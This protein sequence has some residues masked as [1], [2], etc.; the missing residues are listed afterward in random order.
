[1][2]TNKTFINK[3]CFN[4]F[5]VQASDKDSLNNGKLSYQIVD[6]S[7]SDGGYFHIDRD[8]GVVW[9]ARELDFEVKSVLSF[10]V[11]ASDHGAPMQHT[12]VNVVLVVDDVNDNPPVFEKVS[13]AIS[14][15]EKYQLKYL[16][17]TKI[18]LDF[19]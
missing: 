13:V 8:T 14:Y 1:M 3:D 11:R 18:C 2:I 9:T 5:Q 10:V 7:S 12:D 15:L 19:L 6:D 4:C 17:E 16:I